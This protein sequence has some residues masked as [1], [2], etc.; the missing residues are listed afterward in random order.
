MAC[1]FWNYDCSSKVH[2]FILL[3]QIFQLSTEKN[4]DCEQKIINEE[5]V[6]KFLNVEKY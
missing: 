3:A 4:C 6:D 2:F 5:D 1:A